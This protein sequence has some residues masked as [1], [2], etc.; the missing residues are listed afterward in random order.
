MGAGLKVGAQGK[1]PGPSRSGPSCSFLLSN[2]PYPWDLCLNVPSPGKLSV[3][4]PPPLDHIQSFVTSLCA[5]PLHICFFKLYLSGCAG[6][7]LQH[8]ASSFPTR[9]RTWASSVGIAES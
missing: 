9:G 3:A 7:Q 1:Q 8:V 2:S 4:S 5:S 6:S